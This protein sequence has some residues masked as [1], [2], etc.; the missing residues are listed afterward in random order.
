MGFV[1]HRPEGRS[2]TGALMAPNNHPPKSTA[3]AEVPFGLVW[4]G[5]VLLNWLRL[6]L[7]RH[8]RIG[9]PSFVAPPKGSLG[10]EAR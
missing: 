2:I 7:R 5:L 6:P 4:F 1:R 8:S 3:L 9:D 10:F